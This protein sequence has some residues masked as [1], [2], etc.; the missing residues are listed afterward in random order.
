MNQGFK[1]IC[2]DRS[3]LFF[4]AAEW[5][6]PLAYDGIHLSEEGHQ[7]FAKRYLESFLASVSL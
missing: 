6:L 7:V 2:R 5:Q 1:K 4:D 3:V